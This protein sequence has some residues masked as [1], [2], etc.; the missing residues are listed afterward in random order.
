MI[1]GPL[2][3]PASRRGVTSALAAAALL[4][5]LVTAAD[6]ASRFDPALRFRE[7]HTPHFVIYFHQGEDR[8]AQRLA[9]IAEET[10]RALQRPLGV[11]P[12]PRTHVV[13]AD[14]SEFA[15]GYATPVPYDTV[16]IY[17]AW[18]PGTEF[19]VD[20]WLRLAFTHEFTH[21]VHLD[22][23]EGWAHIA[24]RIFGR[25]LYVFPNLF[26]PTWQIEGIAT[27][28]ESAVTGVGRMHAGDFRAI[29]EEAAREQRLEP[30]DR[31]NGGLTDWPAGAAPYGYGAGFHDYLATRFGAESLAA[32][33]DATARRF[34]YTSTRAF[35]YV[36]GESLGDLWRDY[37][38]AETAA[39][40]TAS[41]ST[42][43]PAA[44]I[45]RLTHGGFST[46]GPR[47]DRYACATCPA[48]ILF[49]VANADDFPAL[50]AVTLDGTAPRRVTTR[51]LGST[52]AIGR[53]TIYFDQMELRRN[54]GLYNDLY[55]MSRDGGPVR[56]I[57][58][59]ARLRDPDLSPDGTMLVAAQ[60][61]TG[62]RDL[63]TVRLKPDTTGYTTGD[64]TVISI[65]V[66]APDVYFDTPRWSPDGRSVAVARHRL[67]AMS[68]IVVVDAATK[69]VRV[70]AG[71][72]RTRFAMPAWRPD[73]AA[74]V[75]AAAAPDETF[76]LFEVAV[77]G[78]ACRQLTHTTGGA[79][80]PD[81]SPDGGTIAFA[82]YT[83]A[84]NDIFTMPYPDQ[85]ATPSQQAGHT[86][87]DASW[88]QTRVRPRSDT[89]AAPSAPAE[90]G[91][92][93]ATA[94]TVSG[95]RDYAP[96]P[97]LKPT[98]WTP[99]VR[100][101]ADEVRVGAAVNG[102]DVLGYHTYAVN[103]TWLV[104]APLDAATVNRAA[105][106]WS[107]YYAYDRW[108]PTLYAAASSTTSFFAGPATDQG[109][110]SSATRRERTVEAGVVLPFVHTRV[111]HAA[112]AAVLRTSQ[113]DTRPDG[114]ATA[115]RTPIRAGWQTSTARTYGYSVS[116]EDG[117]L[118]GTTVEIVRHDLGSSADA[119]IATADARVYLPG[120]APH[121]V[122]ALRFSGGLSSGDVTVGRTFLLGGS[123]SDAGV[124][125]FG[126]RASSLLR[127][128]PDATFAGSHVA[129]LN[130]EY[131]WPLARPQRGVGTW[132]ILLHTLH[133]AA[134][135]DAGD[136]WTR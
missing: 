18:P 25:A 97:T 9:V 135:V 123:E 92:A 2:P 131:R 6:A 32:L 79:T 127:G 122:V 76:N 106:D 118:A 27:Y 31:V 66:A 126:S 30:L 111:A 17:T 24:R 100:S 90:A 48:Q 40:R 94:D 51:Y 62:Q 136:A 61:R 93:P 125:N 115:T 28:E 35:L 132:P 37:E 83:I 128:F 42:D 98:S 75:V 7:I 80:W 44:G 43:D 55:A 16:V 15:N 56:Q 21:I 124:L 78:A 14:Q 91:S 1:P 133:A 110:A 39:A 70:V 129:L 119:T 58:S 117:I 59:E 99:V 13:L 23:S 26:L 121:H 10:W 109:T 54:V 71:D 69:A 19:N 95:D 46:S 50:N 103:A 74:L 77:D 29:V 53:D 101:D 3:R 4:S 89:A 47:F 8:A 114:T 86:D 64:T 22:R 130:A 65:L 120:I 60:A 81:V 112:L 88:C 113:E 87:S 45:T 34:P 63:V 102:V 67:G 68:E 96:L 38:A 134:F 5:V 20:D 36:Y 85:S 57:T 105:P 33:A 72:E 12:P 41:G 108:R 49:S 73:G 107:A 116:R 11:M 84:G 104:S 82:G 52:T